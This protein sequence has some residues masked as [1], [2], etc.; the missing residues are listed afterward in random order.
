[1]FFTFPENAHWNA[2]RE[3]VEFGLE[4]GEYRGV[5]ELDGRCCTRAPVRE[6]CQTL[7]TVDLSAI[8]R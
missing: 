3:A 8:E 7:L 1:L 6:A 2:E 5:S 4:I